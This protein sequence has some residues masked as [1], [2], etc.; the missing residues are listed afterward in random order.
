MEE[1]FKNIVKYQYLKIELQK[2]WNLKTICTIPIVFGL[3]GT[4]KQ[5][6]LK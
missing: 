4:A 2:F 1:E 3:L 6:I 5:G